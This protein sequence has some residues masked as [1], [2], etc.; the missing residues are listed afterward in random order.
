MSV[1]FRKQLVSDERYESV[2]VFDVN[3]DGVLDLV[4]GRFWYEGPDYRVAHQICDRIHSVDETYDYFATI[5]LDV[6]GD[7]FT[8]FLSG[9][10]FLKTLKW[11][12]NPGNADEPW[13]EHDIVTNEPIETIPYVDLDGDGEIE[14]FPHTPGG[15]LRF[16]KL[17]RDANGKGTG[18]FAEYTIMEDKQGHGLGFGD[19]NGNGRMDIVLNRGWLEAPEDPYHGDWVLHEEFNLGRSV[20]EP[21]LVVDVTGNG[22]SDIIVGQAH[23]YGLDWWEQKVSATGERSWVKHTIDPENSQYHCLRWVDIDQDG[24]CELVTGK[25]YRAHRGKDPGTAD[26]YGLYYFKWN[27]ESFTKQVIDF[28]PVRDGKGAGIDFAVVDLNGDGRP[29]IVAPGKDGL[30]IYW[31]DGPSPKKE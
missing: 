26:A 21:I 25:R 9:G 27:G 10:W 31:N 12:R 28:G 8:D 20:S 18:E 30:C 3:N 6:D 2:G 5:P 13:S 15:P 16:Y 23:E 24:Q 29:E 4:C 14:I 19:I 22:L 7:G 17:K 1:Q 11:Y